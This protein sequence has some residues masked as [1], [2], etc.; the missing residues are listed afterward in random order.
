MVEINATDPEVVTN[1]FGTYARVAAETAVARLVVPG[2]PTFWV[3]TRL[4]TAREMLNDPR[5]E[6]NAASFMRPPNI[7]DHCLKYMRTMSE[8]N[9]PDHLRL[10]RAVAPAFTP[11]RMDV[12]RPRITEIVDGLI[13]AF[14]GGDVDLVPDF[15]RPLPMDVICTLVGV[16]EADWPSWRT[17]GAAIAA[18]D[19]SAFGEAIPGIMAGAQATVAHRRAALTDDPAVAA[20]DLLGYLLTTTDLTDDELVTLVWQ[21]VLAG[22]TPTNLLTNA[23]EALL[24]HP[25]QDLLAD[26]ARSVEELLRW[27]VRSCSPCPGTPPRTWRWTGS[28]SARANRCP[29]RWWPPAAIPTCS[30]S[31]RPWT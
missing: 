28:V 18:G 12:L 9:G 27:G 23:V 4:N 24:D 6:L 21:L 19:G 16:P 26:P 20:D 11:K 17:W 22:Q 25:D 13:D 2:M 5:F 3:L 14:P 29:R 10:R 15:A 31:R 30:P 1:P 7:P 8:M